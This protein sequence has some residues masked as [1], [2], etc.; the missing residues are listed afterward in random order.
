MA[1]G[2][3]AGVLCAALL[4]LLHVAASSAAG[5]YSARALTDEIKNLPG[6][7]ASVTF[8]QFRCVRSHTRPHTHKRM[9]NTG[10]V[11]KRDFT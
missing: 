6:L 5:G 9:S 1:G 10:C 4:L 11:R 3:G 7:P 2:G 8:K